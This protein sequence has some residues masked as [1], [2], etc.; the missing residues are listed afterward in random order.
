MIEPFENNNAGINDS[1]QVNERREKFCSELFE[2]TFVYIF[3]AFSGAFRAASLSSANRKFIV[4]DWATGQLG[5]QRRIQLRTQWC[6]DF[7]GETAVVGEAR[8]AREP[9][10]CYSR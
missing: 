6:Q 2:F 5:W 8:V 10:A 4:E 3:T 9:F 7:T 1:L